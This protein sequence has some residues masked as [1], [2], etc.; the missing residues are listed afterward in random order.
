MPSSAISGC[1]ATQVVAWLRYCVVALIT[2]HTMRTLNRA[3]L[4]CR[5]DDRFYPGNVPL[6][7]AINGQAEVWDLV[8]PLFDLITRKHEGTAIVVHRVGLDTFD[9]CVVACIVRSASGILSLV[10]L[11]NYVHESPHRLIWQ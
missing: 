2:T 8:R 3:L 5:V 6:Y 1:I 10:T 9:A 7:L 11:P 4:A